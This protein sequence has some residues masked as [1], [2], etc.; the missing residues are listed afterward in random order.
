MPFVSS[1]GVKG[2]STTFTPV[3]LARVMTSRVP[4]AVIITTRKS[5]RSAHARLMKSMPVSS[6]IL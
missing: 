2:L 3:S 4:W 5:G 1:P 6:G